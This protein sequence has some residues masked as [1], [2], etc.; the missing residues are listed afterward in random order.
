M[1]FKNWLKSQEKIVYEGAARTATKTILY[2]LGYGGLGLYPPSW[3]IPYSADAIL[4]ITK[5]ERLFK[6][7]DGPPNDIRHLPGHKKYKNPNS[8]DNPPFDLRNLPGDLGWK[9][10]NKAG[11]KSPFDISKLTGSKDY[12]FYDKANDGSPFSIKHLP[13]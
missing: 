3:Y 9:K 2:P 10:Y 12:K 11:D 7:G 5:D 1:N 6:N 13:K 4:Y 8:H